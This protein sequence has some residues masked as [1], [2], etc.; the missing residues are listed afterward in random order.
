MLQSNPTS[1]R[2]RFTL[3]RGPFELAIEAICVLVLVGT[4]GLIAM[5]WPTLP[6]SIPHHFDFAGNADAWGA[7]WVVLLLPAISLAIYLML[8]WVARHPHRFNYPWPITIDNAA[9]QYRIA[10]SMIL[11]LK[12]ETMI[13]FGYLTWSVI[14]SAASPSATGLGWLFLPFVV[15]AV[16][17]TIAIHL[18]AA[19]RQMTANRRK[20]PQTPKTSPFTI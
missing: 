18:V 15:G 14:R 1:D 17:A 19:A 20:T 6:A 5:S 3:K 13:L 10:Q 16:F 7:R 8:T 4:A 2:P 12:A 11:M 9:S